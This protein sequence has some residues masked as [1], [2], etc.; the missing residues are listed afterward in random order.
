MRKLLLSTA[1]AVF[2]LPQNAPQSSAADVEVTYVV[3]GVKKNAGTFYTDP[4]TVYGGN[5][6]TCSDHCPLPVGPITEQHSW[7][8]KY[9][10][11]V[12]V[13]AETDFIK[14]AGE[15]TR[16]E[17]RSG[18]VT[19]PIGSDRVCHTAA[20]D[21][22]EDELPDA[23][24]VCAP[25]AKCR[26]YCYIPKWY[27]Y[28]AYTYDVYITKKLVRYWKPHPFF[29]DLWGEWGPWLEEAGDCPT[30]VKAY[31]FVFVRGARRTLGF[32]ERGDGEYVPPHPDYL[33]CFC[34]KGHWG[35]LTVNRECIAPP[36]PKEMYPA[37]CPPRLCNDPGCPDDHPLVKKDICTD[38]EGF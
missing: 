30:G 34:A 9:D 28:M 11:S 21:A 33:D 35:D 38:L 10:R 6:P 15:F 18:S 2:L 32:T 4:T 17:T 25:L 1:V 13:G 20:C 7:E 36:T 23:M 31:Q 5:C 19:V 8:T 26:R 16:G 37:T 3:L 24:K 14:F 27:G 12:T 22:S 29:G